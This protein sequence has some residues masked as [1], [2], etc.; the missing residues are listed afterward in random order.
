MWD[1]KK[2]TAEAVVY[3]A[4]DLL[5]ERGG[6]EDALKIFKKVNHL[7]QPELPWSSVGF[8]HFSGPSGLRPKESNTV[9]ANGHP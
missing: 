8:R 4:F 7:G 9:N 2:S 6:A 5:A 3:G 1:G